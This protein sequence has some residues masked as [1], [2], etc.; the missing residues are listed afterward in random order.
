MRVDLDLQPM[1]PEKML[2]RLEE[3]R[4]QFSPAP[5]FSLPEAGGPSGLTG[6]LPDAA[7]GFKPV[8]VGGGMGLSPQGA[9]PELKAM[10]D[11]AAND[12]GVDPLLLDALVACE[13]SY[14]PRCRSRAGAQG[15]TQLMPG[16]AREVGISNPFDPRQSLEGGAKYLARMIEKYGTLPKALAAYNAGPGAVDRHGGIPPYAETQKYVQKVLRLYELRKLNG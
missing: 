6:Q 3:L 15:L 10:I 4:G 13:S 7:N 2:Q 1:G 12:N 16:T 8:T 9:S 5:A 11:K 14:D